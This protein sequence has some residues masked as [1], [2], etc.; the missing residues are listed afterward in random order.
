M[1][2]QLTAPQNYQQLAQNQEVLMR[3]VRQLKM[4]LELLGSLRRWD[5]LTSR[6]RAF[7]KKHKIKQRAVLEDD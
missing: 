5:A 7:A 4:K 3:D 6:T 1:P 2:P